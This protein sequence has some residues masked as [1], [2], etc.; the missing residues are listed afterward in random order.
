MS[1]MHLFYPFKNSS[2][3]TWL[4]KD[5]DFSFLFFFSFFFGG[6]GGGGGV[7]LGVVFCGFFYYYC[8]YYWGFVGFSLSFLLRI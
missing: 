4:N 6:G 5:L 7:E 3:I 2:H 1:L 8:Y